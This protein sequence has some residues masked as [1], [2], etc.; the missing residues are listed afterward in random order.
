M[1][2]LSE[3]AVSVE[4]VTGNVQPLLHELRHALA[5]LA[6]I[7]EE[8]AIDLRGLPL[9]PGEEAQIEE[10]L[11]IGE[12]CAE[13]DALGISTVQETAFSGIWMVTHRNIENEI[14]ARF[15]EVCRMPEILRAQ[16]E[17]IQQSVIRLEQYL[18]GEAPATERNDKGKKN[19]RE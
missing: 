7:G 16:P 11:G 6:S 9:A 4:A 5:R 15:V 3:I 1:S 17:D 2:A 10:A 8:T 14:V 13:V 18:R 19:D 12:V